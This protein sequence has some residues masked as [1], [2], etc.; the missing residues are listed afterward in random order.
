[1]KGGNPTPVS[2]EIAKY[3]GD[4]RDAGI[5]DA[6]LVSRSGHRVDALYGVHRE[7]GVRIDYDHGQ[8]DAVGNIVQVVAL[9]AGRWRDPAY[10]EGVERPAGFAGGIV[11]RHGDDVDDAV[12]ASRGGAAHGAVGYTPAAAQDHKQR[13]EKKSKQNPRSHRIPPAISLQ[14]RLQPAPAIPKLVKSA[15]RNG[16]PSGPTLEPEL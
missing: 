15:T 6:S 16:H 11:F 7:V 12:T 13:G 8:A 2:G 4:G 5:A 9:A 10:V 3:I 14:D 1:M